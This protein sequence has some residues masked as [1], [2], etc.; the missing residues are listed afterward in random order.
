MR[1]ASGRTAAIVLAIAFAAGPGGCGSDRVA[2]TG[3]AGTL[4]DVDGDGVPNRTDKCPF[5][6]AVIRNGCPVVEPAKKGE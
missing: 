4:S 5:D 2:R 1:L 6:H 3:V